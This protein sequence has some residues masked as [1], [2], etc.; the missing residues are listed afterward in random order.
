[1]NRF[2]HIV[3]VVGTLAATCLFILLLPGCKAESETSGPAVK[4]QES[5][6]VVNVRCPIM[7]T[8]IDPQKVPES[9][10]RMHKGKKVGFCCAGCPAAWDKLSDAEK[11]DKLAKVMP[12]KP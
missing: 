3:G 10:T 5:G 2:T 9:L 1:M 4:A 6:K 8:K 12:G 11:D 7:D